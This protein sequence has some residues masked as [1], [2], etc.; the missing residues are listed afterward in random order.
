MAQDV[1]RLHNTIFMMG[2]KHLPKLCAILTDK[3]VTHGNILAANKPACDRS[4]AGKLM[5][6]DGDIAV[7]GHLIEKRMSGALASLRS[8]FCKQRG[9]ASTALLSFESSPI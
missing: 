4:N 1:V 8:V 2:C 6:H 5:D 7:H 3:C 9:E